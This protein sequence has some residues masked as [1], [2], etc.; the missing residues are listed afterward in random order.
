M[1]NKCNFSVKAKPRQRGSVEEQNAKL[2][3]IF[4]KKFKKSGI[5]QELSRSSK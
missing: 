2:V 4:L 1:K 5:V 3:R